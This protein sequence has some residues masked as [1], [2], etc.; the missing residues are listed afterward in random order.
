MKRIIVFEFESTHSHAEIA[1]VLIEKLV[2]SQEIASVFFADDFKSRLLLDG[3]L[4]GRTFGRGLF[5]EKPNDQSEAPR[6]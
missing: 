5:R 2:K 6:Q 4:I 3:N 1:A